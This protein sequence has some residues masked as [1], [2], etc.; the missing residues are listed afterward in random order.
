MDAGRAV[1]NGAKTTSLGHN[2]ESMGKINI[3]LPILINIYH[4]HL[5]FVL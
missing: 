4:A 2:A 1:A 5:H 3:I